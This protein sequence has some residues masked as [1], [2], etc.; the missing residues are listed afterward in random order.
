[1]KKG[2]MFRYKI[3]LYSL[4]GDE[5]IFISDTGMSEQF[6]VDEAW[7][8]CFPDEPEVD[9]SRVEVFEID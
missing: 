6:A 1:M 4:S 8:K 9:I 2:N 7:G 3:Y 5:Y